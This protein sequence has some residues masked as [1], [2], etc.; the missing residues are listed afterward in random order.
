M[1]DAR[2][3][4][5]ILNKFRRTPRAKD[6]LIKHL[7]LIYED[8]R[9]VDVRVEGG[10]IQVFIDEGR[11]AIPATRLSDG[12]L[13]WLCLLAI[14]LNPDDQFLVCIEEP[15]L[16]LHPDLLLPLADLLKEASERMQLVVT[17]HSD[18]LISALSDTPETVLVCEKHEGSTT[19]RRFSKDELSD[20]LKDYS[21]GS[22]GV[23]GNSEGIA[24]ES[25]HLRRGGR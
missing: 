21:L 20:W 2:N 4:G 11:W 19:M 15:E 5:L 25:T 16:G 8:V 14:L 22:S 12:T 23:V 6:Q 13:R 17:T 24:G 1:E 18:T 9:D 7:K 3:L 10:T